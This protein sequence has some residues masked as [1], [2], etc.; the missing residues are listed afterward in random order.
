VGRVLL[1]GGD[2]EVHEMEYGSGS[3]GW[4]GGSGGAC[5]VA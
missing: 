4:L 3:G 1:G 5:V 2:G